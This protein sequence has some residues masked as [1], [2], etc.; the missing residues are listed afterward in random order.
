MIGKRYCPQC[1]S[2]NVTPLEGGDLDMW[3]CNECGHSAADFP[4]TSIVKSEFD[5]GGEEEFDEDE[6]IEEDK[7]KKKTAKKSAKKVKSKPKKKGGKK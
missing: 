3:I 1:E 7:P 4:Q 6:D 2:D 5:E